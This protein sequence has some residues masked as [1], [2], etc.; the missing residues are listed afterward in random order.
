MDPFDAGVVR[1]AYDVAAEDYVSS[2][3]NDLA[4]LPVDRAI[5]DAAV[6]QIVQNGLVLDLGCGP[7]QIAHYLA[8]RGAHVVGLDLSAQMLRLAP[9]HPATDYVC[10]DMRLLP[11][12]SGSFSAMV[13]FYS[14]Q[15]L[16]RPALPS[17]LIEISRVLAPGGLLVVAAHLGVGETYI[18]EF[19]GHQVQR[20]GG[21][22]YG[23]DE[24]QEVLRAHRFSIQV[25]RQRDPL[26]H[27]YRSVRIYLIAQKDESLPMEKQ[28]VS[29]ARR[30]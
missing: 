27:E 23:K 21:T 10:G 7:G 14:I 11:F 18:E 30:R 19:L 26:P 3:V 2:F 22:L 25:S 13:A 28:D 1:S 17:L 5:L 29:T 12:R 20:V 4:D 9:H 15:H 16:A 24:L 6:E 8:D